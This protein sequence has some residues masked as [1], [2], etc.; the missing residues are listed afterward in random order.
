M[1]Q[2]RLAGAA[3][4]ALYTAPALALLLQPVAPSRLPLR[5]NF[6]SRAA[7]VLAVGEAGANY[8]VGS[9]AWPARKPSTVAEDPKGEKEAAPRKRGRG[10][11]GRC[12]ICP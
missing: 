5:A 12:S 8:N 4:L 11:G 6:P 1:A 7:V 10:R 9:G 3:A 2:V